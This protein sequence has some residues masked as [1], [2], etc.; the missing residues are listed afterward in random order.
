MK[1]GR[2]KRRFIQVIC[3]VLYNCNITGF[4]KGK[5][6]QGKVKGA[7]VPGLN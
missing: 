3:A 5:I 6:Y 7:C 1:T 2:A 4:A